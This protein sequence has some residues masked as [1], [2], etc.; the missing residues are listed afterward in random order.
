MGDGA[1]HRGELFADVELARSVYEVT[2]PVGEVDW[3]ELAESNLGAWLAMGLL[4][5]SR[6]LLQAVLLLHKADALDAGDSLARSIL[7]YAITG[8]WLLTDPDAHLPKFNGA[9]LAHLEEMEMLKPDTFSG[10][11]KAFLVAV[12]DAQEAR[13]P[14]VKRRMGDLESIYWAYKLLCETTHPTFVASSFAFDLEEDADLP[15]SDRWERTLPS[16]FVIFSALWTWIL[17]TELDKEF[18]ESIFA[19]DLQ[20]LSLE[21]LAA[22]S[23]DAESDSFD[24]PEHLFKP[25]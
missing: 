19:G 11:S 10:I 17:A 14:G 6:R 9:T 25:R 13:L 8:R 4:Q 23:Y 20:D 24:I 21:L 7:E 5:R 2:E 18:E 3:L 1:R 15:V 16:Q 22:I 12:P